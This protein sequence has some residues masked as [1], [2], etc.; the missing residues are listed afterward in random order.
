MKFIRDGENSN[1]TIIFTLLSLE[2]GDGDVDDFNEY[3]DD[4]EESDDQ[5]MPTE[6]EV[7]GVFH[8]EFFLNPIYIFM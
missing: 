4:D 8:F 6:P 2:L 7:A 3:S 1:L 5:E